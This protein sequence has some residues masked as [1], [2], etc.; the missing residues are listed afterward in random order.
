VD[1]QELIRTTQEAHQRVTG[2]IRR[3][4]DERLLEP[5]MDDWTG[6][7]V[8]A[9]LA[10]WHD[11]SALVIEGL[12][13]G[14]EPYDRDDPG[15][16]TDAFNE[17]VHREHAG[18]PPE[19]VRRAFDESFSRLLAALEPA[20]DEE[21]FAED[22]WPWLGGEALAET[23]LWDSSRHY[24]DHREHLERLSGRGAPTDP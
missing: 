6:K 18:D 24:E 13:A 8:L 7:D 10:W 5:A 14:R 19:L 11:H 2:M 20:T 15:N 16:G 12:R 9:H 17:R 21:L 1:K 23:V 3:V 4:P 22:R